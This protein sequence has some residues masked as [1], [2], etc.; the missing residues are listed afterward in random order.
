[1]YCQIR[2]TIRW[3]TRAYQRVM[4]DGKRGTAANRLRSFRTKLKKLLET[5]S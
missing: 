1:M 4:L 5:I 2:F 3:I